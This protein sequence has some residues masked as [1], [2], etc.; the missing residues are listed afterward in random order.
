MKQFSHNI[1]RHHALSVMAFFLLLPMA[2]SAQ[3]AD[4]SAQSAN[5]FDMPDFAF[6]VEVETRADSALRA[7]V[8]RKDYRTA[9]QALIQLWV[10]RTSVDASRA[11]ACIAETDSVCAAFPEPW[12]G[13]GRLLEASM[14]R[15]VYERNMWQYNQR[16][17][18]LEPI[19]SSMSEWSR[20]HFALRVLD[21]TRQA[22]G[23]LH[24][25]LPLDS[26]RGVVEA[27]GESWPSVGSFVALNGVQTLG[28][29]ATSGTRIPFGTTGKPTLAAEVQAE[30]AAYAEALL[31]DSRDAAPAARVAALCAYARL[32]APDDA[33]SR[34]LDAYREMP[35]D[36]A[37]PL[38]LSTAYDMLDRRVDSAPSAQLR[39]WYAEAKAAVARFPGAS[40]TAALRNQIAEL[41]APTASVEG[42]DQY[43]A[44]REMK[45]KVIA[46]NT[47]SVR[48]V[49]Y[50]LPAGMKESATYADVLA[51]G[52][53]VGSAKVSTADEIPFAVNDTV[54]FPAQQPGVYSAV[55]FAGDSR[56][57]GA[58]A[59]RRAT[60]V[61]VSNLALVRGSEAA[62]TE[63]R[64]YV[65]DAR[66]QAPV[67]GATL[68][69]TS[70]Q[71]GVA[72]V[73]RRSD[74]SG[75]VSA[76]I[77]NY[78]LRVAKGTDAIEA[79][80]YYGGRT[81]ADRPPRPEGRV[82]T[83]RALYRRG[84][85]VRFVAVVWR[86]SGMDAAM[87]KSLSITALLR[88]ANGR[89][90]DT[91]QLTSDNYGRA[92]GAFRLPAEC[93]LGSFT[94]QISSGSD[95]I[96]S[97]SFEVAAYE[98]PTF[99]V[100]V[101]SV[102]GALECGDTI[103]IAGRAMTY[104]GLPVRDADVKFDVRYVSYWLRG[105]ASPDA[106]YGG[107]TAT[108]SDGTFE[109]LLPT[110]GLRGTPY[111]RGC[112]SLGVSA[113]DAA[114]ETQQAN[115]TMFALGK[116][117]RI[118][119]QLPG[120]IDP[121]NAPAVVAVQ[122]YDL[123][124]ASASV[125]VNYR[126]I[127]DG[128]TVGSGK[129][130][131][132]DFSADWKTLAEGRYK[133]EFSVGDSL[134]MAE[135][136]VI[137]WRHDS[138]APP[139]G[140]ILWVPTT[141]VVAPSGAK[142]VDVR[143][144]S[145]APDSYLLWQATDNKGRST[146]GWLRADSSM[147]TLPVDIAA[148]A[149][150]VK[151]NITAIR[152]LER[153]SAVVD[154][155]TQAAAA[156]P[157]IE[158]V[159]FRDR[160]V[161]GQHED[162]TFRITYD[163]KPAGVVPAIATMTDRSLDAIVP[164]GWS[165]AWAVMPHVASSLDWVHTLGGGSAFFD[166][167]RA[168]WVD[169]PAV[170]L[171]EWNMYGY[172][173]GSRGFAT[174]G[175]MLRKTVTTDG[176]VVV[177][178]MAQVYASSAN[179]APMKMQ[180]MEANDMTDSVEEEAAVDTATGSA[181][182][183]TD[184]PAQ[185]REGEIPVAF[186]MPDLLSDAAGV[187]SVRFRVPNANAAWKLQLLGYMPNARAALISLN[188]VSVKPV[189]ISINAPRTLL[190]GDD[191]VVR[192]TVANTTDSTLSV[193]AVFEAIDPA[194]GRTLGQTRLESS[195]LGAKESRVVALRFDVGADCQMIVLRAVASAPGFSDGEQCLVGILPA[196]APV[197][198]ASTFYF[199]PGA[200]ETVVSVPGGSRRATV[201]FEYCAN[202]LWECLTALPALSEPAGKST[203]SL[204]SALTANALALHLARK[205]PKIGEALA[206]WKELPDSV[207]P[208]VSPL[209]QNASTHTVD[210]ALT[211]WLNNAESAGLRMQR[212]AELTDT[213]RASVV[214][215]A[216]IA[217]L[218]S[219]A[220]AD[221]GWSWQPG[222]PTS[223]FI[224]S[225]VLSRLATLRS[226]GA[227]P[228]EGERLA[229]RG[230]AYCDSRFV[231][232]W[233]KNGRKDPGATQM[234]DYLYSRV[235]FGATL[236]ESKD[237]RALA[238]AA[239]KAMRRDWRKLSPYKAA[240]AA[241]VLSAAGSADV[242]SQIL[243]SLR[244]RA[245]RNPKQGW[246]YD[247]GRGFGCTDRIATTSR[248]LEAF[249]RIAPQDTA[250]IDALRQWI[251]LQKRTQEWSASA[252]TSEA[253]AALL[254][255]GSDW[256]S[257]EMPEV[258]IGSRRVNFT[259]FDKFTGSVFM[260]LDAT[261][262]SRITIAHKGGSP[263]WGGVMAQYVLPVDEARPHNVDELKIAREIYRVDDSA[264]GTTL[265][266]GPLRIGQRVRVV[267][268]LTASRDVDYVAVVDPRPACLRPEQQLSGTAWADGTLFYREVDTDATRFFINRLRRGTTIITYDAF[269]DMEG[270]YSA[271]PASAQ[272]L[273]APMVSAGTSGTMLRVTE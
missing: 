209:L 229:L 217:D 85:S 83:D 146:Y 103:R 259:D 250:M 99:Y 239:L 45:F 147:L 86:G 249:A 179:M 43:L 116:A 163:G 261:P 28:V 169:Q 139:K 2:V 252:A 218:A 182:A 235:P 215:A 263:A 29:F 87:E 25:P 10:A 221:G 126:L 41:T 166:F 77:G 18:P 120:V 145:A 202:P 175:G 231:A 270:N 44:G 254:T 58:N 67:G 14:M 138:P 6:P 131:A 232:D 192:A 26:L 90:V 211:P 88:D 64:L 196:T 137:L 93:M 106:T 39:E 136:E 73:V 23:A 114:G 104:T 181:A 51:K 75:F 219:R 118:S 152:D 197:V 84:D 3:S 35:T 42:E 89:E 155:S 170:C 68:T 272:S 52:R 72:S 187:A 198:D 32:I 65:V 113:T 244:Q 123:V 8:D 56:S 38:L 224:T 71:R 24:S 108:S 54:I 227:L 237:F 271:A 74:A 195:A 226:F 265:S 47:P 214:V 206:Y 101:D 246:S 149:A 61:R 201:S 172:R 174:R 242:A 180:K 143:V 203:T 258:R 142:T 210:V 115:P 130:R 151:L 96:S 216:Q 63:G 186:F 222:L 267:L 7:A 193:G 225:A 256:T 260:Q 40:S 140:E 125:D 112:F 128:R 62:G 50:K 127:R 22:A 194:S 109:I 236:K 111:S 37:A 76:P 95:K 273:Y 178:E 230:F 162:W 5:S 33:A 124:G 9:L 228:E 36:S 153:K 168:K 30:R 262:G 245:I 200:S 255:S 19:P 208:L 171:P 234:L 241:V 82:L 34:L 150:R 105:G 188:A 243:E 204:A 107:T 102:R 167:G 57:L 81:Y 60:T 257:T 11:G 119:P 253:V 97:G 205:Q 13:V 233:R 173:F 269:V 184:E 100:E 268:T 177:E 164:F 135:S 190:T 117:Y 154:I 160:I 122:V 189:T 70:Q 161:P 59:R 66:N 110:A 49:L 185:M 158:V 4:R 212:L 55:A 133:V 48:V 248:V 132:P 213:A 207:S 80:Y 251:V 240:T 46:S 176:A 20:D 144:G 220:N 148:D 121:G 165:S 92:A 12:R 79:Y 156:K 78:K 266:S 27:C 15:R 94:I 191:P 17:L 98:R 183:S 141:S 69:F 53:E 1:L 247:D 159:S 91:L 129:F 238:D 223:E 134:A 264:D 157:Q 199:A 16:N 31:A 21:L